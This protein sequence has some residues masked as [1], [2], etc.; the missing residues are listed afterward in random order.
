MR[1]S[2]N[3]ST[4][5]LV[6]NALSIAM[7]IAIVVC[8]MSVMSLSN[9]IERAN[10]DRFDL[11]YN[12]NRFMDGSAYLTN[13]VRAFAV[14]GDIEHYNNY[15]DEINVFKNRDIGVARMKE[16]GIT[17]AE[18]A[19]IDKMSAL[20]NNL[21]PLES[22][23]MDKTMAGLREEAI[24]DVYG[25]WYYKWIGE[26]LGTK[27]EFL[28]MLD[29]RAVQEV[30]AL[31]GKSN[32]LQA[33]TFVFIIIVTVLQVVNAA[34]VLL[35]AILPVKILQKE[36]EEVAQGN[37]S[38]V[39]SLEANTSEIGRLTAAVLEIKSHLATYIG[40]ISDKLR[41][42]AEG[43]LNQHVDIDYIGDYAPIKA[44]LE[45]II[46]SLNDTLSQINDSSDQV[47]TG[48]KHIADGAQ[49][50]AQGTTEQ[51]SAVEELSSSI[52]EINNM[53]KE[54]SQLAAATLKDVQEAD[55]LMGICT[56]QMSQMI[57]AMRIIDEK[58]KGILK[59]TKVIDDIAFQTNILALNAAVEAARAGQHG[60]GFAVV[61]EEVRNL[62]SK[63]SEAA[64]ETSALLESSS[65]SVEEG[66]RIVEQVSAS[67]QSVAE[68]AHRNSTN[69]AQVQQISASQSS[70]MEQ[71][72]TGIDQVANVVQ[73]NSATAEES[74]AASQEMSSQ[75]SVLLG[76]ISKFNLKGSHAAYRVAPQRETARQ[77]RLAL[78][79]KDDDAYNLLEKEAVNF[80]K[81]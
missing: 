74:A 21:V 19:M 64:K 8:F 2:I 72:N 61:A 3:Q 28:T 76:L 79:A 20:S 29:A 48:A 22:D 60:K 30:N 23:A 35:K 57:A 36:M 45:T 7:I 46:G 66:N 54:N 26:I 15:W 49:S 68:I 55:S 71:V 12:A 62:A 16:I 38:T 24:E 44:A 14:T 70:A 43:D 78:L 11:T 59:T 69:I 73:Q 53:A 80:G 67:L 56:E 6:L 47:S 1:K 63:S 34:Y 4:M 31:I 27:D 32:Q 42:L 39:L 52:N 25:E 75:S 40:D 50:L 77:S 65:Q 37:L 33:L 10:E 41:R 58:S 17:K 5:V 81:Y 9:A 51:A 13:E 18:E